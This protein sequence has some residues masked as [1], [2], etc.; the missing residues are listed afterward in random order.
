MKSLQKNWSLLTVEGALFIFLGTLA[1]ILPIIFS[2]GIVYTLGAILFAGGLI[3][4]FRTTKFINE[5]Y[6]GP[7][8]LS[9]VIALLIGSAILIFP[10][11]GLM[12]LTLL[13]I[14]YFIF[15][16]FA[17]I[18]FA[19]ILKPLHSWG[20]MLA[21]GILSLVFSGVLIA[22][23]PAVAAFTLGILFG[24]NMLF[25]GLTLIFAGISVKG[26]FGESSAT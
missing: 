4:L 5:K 15:E 2:F 11:K 10:A 13:L 25:F 12:F 8:L 3:Q 6:F 21:S 24:V 20:L 22:F 18:I 9:S 19:F 23:W 7:S 14:G 1:I 26:L 17:K 16:G